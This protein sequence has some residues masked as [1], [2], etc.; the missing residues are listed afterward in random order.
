VE[1]ENI[2][3]RQRLTMPPTNARDVNVE[4][5]DHISILIVVVYGP[6]LVSHAE[7]N[8]ARSYTNG[9]ESVQ[10]LGRIDIRGM[11]T[12]QEILVKVGIHESYVVCDMFGRYVAVRE[13]AFE[14][15]GN[16]FEDAWRCSKVL[17]SEGD[18]SW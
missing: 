14:L 12:G 9:E 4:I 10:K 7:G 11:A 2:Q 15:D 3:L 8:C 6:P 13:V 18:F 1:S 5:T 17:H 16:G